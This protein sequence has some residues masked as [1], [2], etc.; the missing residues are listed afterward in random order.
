MSLIKALLLTLLVV[1]VFRATRFFY[2]VYK[3]FNNARN[4]SQ[5]PQQE[6]EGNVTL[7]TSGQKKK[8]LDND[9]GEYVPFD[10]VD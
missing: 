6:K 2:K 8:K 4:Q 9:V 3:A 10:E 1:I 7:H 5:K